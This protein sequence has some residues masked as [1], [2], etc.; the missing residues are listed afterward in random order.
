MRPGE[1][2]KYTSRLNRLGES[3][4]NGFSSIGKINLF[5]CLAD[6]IGFISLKVYLK[7]ECTSIT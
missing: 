4:T 1:G 7:K 6:K 3:S 2:L 5:W